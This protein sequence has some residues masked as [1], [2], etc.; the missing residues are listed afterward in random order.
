MSSARVHRTLRDLFKPVAVKRAISKKFSH[1][2]T[3][4]YSVDLLICD[5]NVYGDIHMMQSLSAGHDRSAS[6]CRQ[7]W[8]K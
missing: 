1:S 3:C 6:L 5:M 7:I 4:G 2:T 8:K